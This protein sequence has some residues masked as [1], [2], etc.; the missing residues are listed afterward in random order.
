MHPWQFPGWGTRQI[1]TVSTLKYLFMSAA[2]VLLETALSATAVGQ[3]APESQKEIATAPGTLTLDVGYGPA[4]AT[5]HIR[6]PEIDD[7]EVLSFYQIDTLRV[8]L[9]TLVSDEAETI[10]QLEWEVQVLDERFLDNPDTESDHYLKVDLDEE[11]RILTF[12]TTRLFFASDIPVRLFVEDPEGLSD[13]EVFRLDVLPVEGVPG[14][15]YDLKQNY[16]NPFHQE[17]TIE[18]WIPVRARVRITVYDLLGREVIRLVDREVI[19]PGVHTVRWRPRDQAS[20]LYIYRLEAL[21][22]D[23]SRFVLSQELTLVR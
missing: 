18:F 11:T 1:P 10:D 8:A 12:S 13:E 16:P 23:G 2:L 4:R 20:G 9:D 14:K 15:V 7:L 6:A 5:A 17:T 22:S 3:D 19:S 21:G